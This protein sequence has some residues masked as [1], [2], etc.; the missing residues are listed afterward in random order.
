MPRLRRD[1][2]VEALVDAY[3]TDLTAAGHFAEN[4][5]TS[6]ARAF[7]APEAGLENISPRQLRHTSLLRRSTAACRWRQSPPCSVT[8]R[9][10]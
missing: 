5:V 3:Q 2:K 8:G 9:C 4:E 10:G 6:P 1:P 7:L